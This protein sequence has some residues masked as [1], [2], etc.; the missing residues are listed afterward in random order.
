MDHERLASDLIRHLRGKRSQVAFSRRLGYRGNVA[1]PWETGRR[2][3][4]ASAFFRAAQRL[5]RDVPTGLQCF[6]G[7]PS[8]SGIPGD[9]GSVAV[10]L[11]KMRGELPVVTVAELV[12]VDRS[13]AARWLKGKT[14]PRLPALLAW[15]EATT[16]RLLEFIELY[17]NPAELPAA[18]GAY[19]TMVL[20][21]ELAY[22]LPWS[23]AVLRAL[24]LREYRALP[25]HRPGFIASVTGMPAALEEH[26]LR[27]LAAAGQIRRSRGRWATCNVMTVDTRA[28]AARNRAVKAHWARVG[29]ERLVASQTSHRSLF[30]YNL[31]AVSRE[32]FEQIRQLHID[33]YER[34][35]AV[36]A[37]S[38][39]ADR[40][41]LVNQQ[42]ID[43]AETASSEGS[44]PPPSPAGHG[45]S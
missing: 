42:L 23:H 45:P 5:G 13:T 3:P 41:V 19:R 18:R 37:A 6:L 11:E 27:Q 4:E 39:G 20:Q 34:V 12:H 9:P 31:F 8:A 7:D 26:C 10:L 32:D 1:Y 44:L 14:E 43:L 38:T 21:R 15:V 33:Y 30:S 35:R 24:E 29:E 28:D 40:V 2:F 17:V 22:E 36:V 16:H 25:R